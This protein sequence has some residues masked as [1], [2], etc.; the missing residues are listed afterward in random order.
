MLSFCTS[1]VE[2]KCND[3]SEK[4]TRTVN[5]CSVDGILLTLPVPLNDI[6]FLLKVTHNFLYENIIF[7]S[8]NIDLTFVSTTYLMLIELQQNLQ[9]AFSLD[10]PT[11][12]SVF[13]H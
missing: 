2:R 12:N 3:I 11:H 1:F 10:Q 5:E 4:I 13:T 7:A 6:T 8:Q 9:K